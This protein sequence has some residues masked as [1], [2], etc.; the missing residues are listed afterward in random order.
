MKEI[1]FFKSILLICFRAYYWSFQNIL[2]FIVGFS[3]IIILLIHFVESINKTDPSTIITN[4][5][6]AFGMYFNLFNTILFLQIFVFVLSLILLNKQ[7]KKVLEL[8]LL[9]KEMVMS[10]YFIENVETNGFV[11]SDQKI[12]VNSASQIDNLK[13]KDLCIFN[14]EIARILFQ[15][16]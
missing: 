10:E 16:N 8:R 2:G 4:S 3:T 7:D 6:T 1:Y 11:L 15:K 5:F 12:T 14:M 13:V 9:L